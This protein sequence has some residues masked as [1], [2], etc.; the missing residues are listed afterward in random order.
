MNVLVLGGDGYCGWPTALHLSRLGHQVGIVD[1]FIRRMWDYELGVE[2]LTPIR[3]LPTRVGAWRE[4]AGLSMGSFV[5][6]LCDYAFVQKVFERFSPDAIVHFAEQRSAP[7]SMIDR[8]HALLTQVNNITGTLN[9]LFA[10]RDLA[11]DCH[12]VK[13]GTM[14]EYGTPNI[15]I[16]EGFIEIR[17][18]GRKDFLPFPK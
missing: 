15:D 12:M 9:L 2:T 13:L 11:P 1:N 17:H 14:G 6:D 7:Y 16:E 3:S 5:G 8:E 10:M 18:N 4:C